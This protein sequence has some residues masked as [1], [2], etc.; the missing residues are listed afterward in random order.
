M[1]RKLTA[2][3][4]KRRADLMREGARLFASKGYHPTAVA[5]IVASLGVGKGVFYW[6]FSS[7]QEFYVEILRAAQ[8]DL[9]RNQ[10]A[11]IVDE[12]DPIVRIE[13][14]IEASV[15]WF[16]EHR[17]T[18]NLFQFAATEEQFAPVLREGQQVAVT[19][20]ARHI[21]EGIVEGRIPDRDPEILAQAVVGVMS[22]LARVYL[23]ERDEPVE[24]VAEA[25]RAFC[26]HGLLGT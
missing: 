16:H 9:R 19:D 14:G 15:R 4:R 11:A 26:L 8:T 1:S 13:S 5:D 2:R 3:G 25:A 20:A 7:K 12:A 10:Q 21:K 24:T 23:Y 18:F 22:H 17:D 6:Y